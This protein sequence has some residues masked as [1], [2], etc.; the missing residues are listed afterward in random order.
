MNY[1]VASYAAT[2][3]FLL[4]SAFSGD[5]D[6]GHGLTTGVSAYLMLMLAP[7][8]PPILVYGTVR[9]ASLE[10]LAYLIVF[11]ATF[12]GFLLVTRNAAH[13]QR[14]SRE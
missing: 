5:V 1:I 2:I 8:F 14:P 4:W 3:T 13:T 12:I 10:G 9:E 11:M 7:I 6:G